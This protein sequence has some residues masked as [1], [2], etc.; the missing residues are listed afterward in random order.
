MFKK[1][2]GFKIS[3]FLWTGPNERERWIGIESLI[4]LPDQ[5]FVLR[6]R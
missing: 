4:P 1:P 3:R 6:E 5:N 2:C